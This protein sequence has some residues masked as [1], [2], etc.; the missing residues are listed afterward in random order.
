VGAGTAVLDLVV[1]VVSTTASNYVRPAGVTGDFER[2]RKM[3]SICLNLSGVA[4]PQNSNQMVTQ[5]YRSS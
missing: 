2:V 5:G 1:T 3:Q 4:A